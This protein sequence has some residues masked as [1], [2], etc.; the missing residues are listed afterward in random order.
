VEVHR[1]HDLGLREGARV[2]QPPLLGHRLRQLL[3]LPARLLAPAR[4]S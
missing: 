1:P 2:A 3:A 4:V